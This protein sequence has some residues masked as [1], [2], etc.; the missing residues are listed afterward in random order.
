M[1]R[2]K[3]VELGV[4]LA[5]GAICSMQYRI[6]GHGVLTTAVDECIALAKRT[7]GDY[8]ELFKEKVKKN[9]YPRSALFD[10]LN[11]IKSKY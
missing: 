2:D 1:G 3:D 9:E 7:M 8:F 5:Y 10:Q 4:A 6:R 11:S